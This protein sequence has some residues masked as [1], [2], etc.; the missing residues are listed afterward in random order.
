MGGTKSR[1]REHDAG[2]EGQKYIIK[3]LCVKWQHASTQQRK[4]KESRCICEEQ[5][6]RDHSLVADSLSGFPVALLV[7]VLLF[8]LG[9]RLT[10]DVMCCLWMSLKEK[11]GYFDKDEE[12]RRKKEMDALS[13]LLA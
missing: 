11:S 1:V 4:K 3:R 13:V 7:A 2:D 9:D 5:D 12:G 6:R 8:S 10:V